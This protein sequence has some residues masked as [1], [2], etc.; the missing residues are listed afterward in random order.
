MT[1][2]VWTAS[3]PDPSARPPGVTLRRPSAG[4]LLLMAVLLILAL[5]LLLLLGLIL[6]VVLAVAAGIAAVRRRI[7]AW[8][9][10][11]RDRE[12]RQNVRVRGE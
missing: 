6:G 5:P 3:S 1:R 2:F 10:G 9:P 7:G 12:G 8:R 4:R 11:G